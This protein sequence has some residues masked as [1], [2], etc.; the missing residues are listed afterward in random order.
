MN[1]DKTVLLLPADAADRVPEEHKHRP[2][3]Y[4]SEVLGGVRVTTDPGLTIV[5]SP[6]GTD[7]H[8]EKAVAT[9]LQDPAADTLL[10]TVAG[11]R[12]TQGA[13]ALLRMC[14]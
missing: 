9:T 3:A 14:S 10:R 7:A 5:G 13:L 2:H 8:V 12:A 1:T 6:L 4:A 11:M